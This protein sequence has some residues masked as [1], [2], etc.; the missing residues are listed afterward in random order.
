[1]EDTDP[2]FAKWLN[3]KPFRPPN[4]TTGDPNY[5]TIAEKIG[6][7]TTVWE[8]NECLLAHVF[9]LMCDA[10][11]HSAIRGF[12]AVIGSGA[13]CDMVLA[14][15]EYFLTDNAKKPREEQA[16]DELRL[17]EV[18]RLLDVFRRISALRNVAAHSVIVTRSKTEVSTAFRRQGAGEF[19]LAPAL[20][21]TGKTEPQGQPKIFWNAE[22]LELIIEQAEVLQFH[23]W[24]LAYG[25]ARRPVY[26]PAF[27]ISVTMDT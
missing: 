23:L 27:S 26:P 9:F 6:T 11:N 12:G 3:T 16:V 17:G 8:V 18:R 4:A 20:Y 25:Y 13:R 14:A 19:L 21:N 2:T 24:G 1:M 7:L 5:S 15:A 22:G 10:R